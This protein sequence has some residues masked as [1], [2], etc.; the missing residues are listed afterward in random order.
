VKNLYNHI[1]AQNGDMLMFSPL[2]SETNNAFNADTM[3]ISYPGA[4]EATIVP[5]TSPE[6]AVPQIVDVASQVNYK[7][8]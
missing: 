3:K 1:A 7:D 2:V 6:D 8:Y 5:R 4:S